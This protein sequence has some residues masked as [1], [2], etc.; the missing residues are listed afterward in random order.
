[1]LIKTYTKINN[2]Q[3]KTKDGKE[4]MII[5]VRT[6]EEKVENN[7]LEGRALEN[8]KET[9]EKI[10]NRINLCDTWVLENN[11]GT[12][13]T[14]IVITKEGN[15]DL[16]LCIMEKYASKTTYM[17]VGNFQP[18]FGAGTV[19]LEK[20]KEY[21]K[22]GNMLN[23][24]NKKCEK[25]GFYFDTKNNRNILAQARAEYKKAVTV[26][27]KINIVDAFEEELINT[28]KEDV[29]KVLEKIFINDDMLVDNYYTLSDELNDDRNALNTLAVDSVREVVEICLEKNVV[30]DTEMFVID[31]AYDNLEGICEHT[32][33]MMEIIRFKEKNIV[34]KYEDFIVGDIYPVEDE[35]KIAKFELCNL[36]VEINHEEKEV[37][38]YDV[39]KQLEGQ[40][41]LISY[42]KSIEESEKLESPIKIKTVETTEKKEKK[43]MDTINKNTL[44]NRM[45]KL[46]EF[47]KE[48]KDK[49]IIEN[50]IYELFPKA[51]EVDVFDDDD[52]TIFFLVG[53]EYIG[54]AP[55]RK[56]MRELD[57]NYGR[58]TRIYG[59]SVYIEV[60]TH[61]IKIQSSV[62]IDY[63]DIW[64]Y[65]HY[66]NYTVK[67]IEIELPLTMEVAKEKIEYLKNRYENGM[68]ASLAYGYITELTRRECT[69][70]V[71]KLVNE[72]VSYYEK[73]QKK[74]DE[75]NKFEHVYK[76]INK[77]HHMFAERTIK[78]S[79]ALFKLDRLYECCYND[80]LKTLVDE[81][82]ELYKKA[83]DSKYRE[84]IRKQVTELVEEKCREGLQ[85]KIN[86]LEKEVT[87]EITPAD[88]NKILHK[89]ALFTNTQWNNEDGFCITTESKRSMCFGVGNP[90]E[91]EDDYERVVGVRNIQ[92]GI[93]YAKEKNIIMTFVV[94]KLE[95]IKNGEV[96]TIEK[97][98]L[99][100]KEIDCKPELEEDNII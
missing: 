32:K 80:E 27:E 87:S 35:E 9:L 11:E 49:D 26:E 63:V 94:G 18:E 58:T 72:V 77:I 41:D 1:M 38:V 62:G 53:Q 33:T 91:I 24:L 19:F 39:T 82:V 98:Y 71:E 23:A 51:I 60:D 25:Y 7:I 59:L 34:P 40:V 65:K 84:V 81:T 6:L 67:K 22:L 29:V 48:T 64:G 69:E 30:T 57:E 78:I 14:R 20:E 100:H 17:R 4:E 89:M 79:R 96:R 54:K 46:G 70:E 55:T 50:K 43:E 16:Y 95:Y 76:T 13:G 45:K 21:Q 93:E 47:L 99:F 68:S 5:N 83:E 8:A 10:E 56:E 90:D 3:N 36:R 75:K 31:Y 52:E 97:H 74:E 15:I 85:E 37:L 42:E 73:E 92:Y 28:P 44:N 88:A 86:I 2:T 12:H 66:T 61:E